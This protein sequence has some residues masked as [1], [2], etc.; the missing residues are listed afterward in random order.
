MSNLEMFRMDSD[1]E[2]IARAD[3]G[4]LE[5]RGVNVDDYIHTNAAVT[6]VI[7]NVWYLI[8]K[9]LCGGKAAARVSQTINSFGLVKSIEIL[10]SFADDL[11]GDSPV[12]DWIADAVDYCGAAKVIQALSFPKRFAPKGIKYKVDATEAF[13]QMQRLLSA[14]AY[15][16][17][18]RTGNPIVDKTLHAKTAFYGELT[19]AVRDTIKMLIGEGPD[20]SMIPDGPYLSPGASLYAGW[21]TSRSPAMKLERY[22][23]HSQTDRGPNYDE[24]QEPRFVT[25]YAEFTVEVEYAAKPELFTEPV[26][27]VWYIGVRRGFSMCFSEE[28]HTFPT[29]KHFYVRPSLVFKPGE[30][31]N[32]FL[33]LTVGNCKYGAELV[34]LES[35]KYV[36]GAAW[37]ATHDGK[38]R[39][40]KRLNGLRAWAVKLMQVP[41]NFKT[42]RT[43]TVERAV[44]MSDQLR[45]KRALEWAV[46]RTWVGRLWL[47]LS[48][49]TQNQL[50]AW[51][52]SLEGEIATIDISSASDWISVDLARDCFPGGWYRAFCSTRPTHYVVTS[53]RNK[54]PI[55]QPLS[56][57]G[58][59]GV[60]WTFLME[61]VFYLAVSLVAF[62]YAEALGVYTAKN[63]IQHIPDNFK[64]LRWAAGV[65]QTLPNGITIRT[66]FGR[67]YICTTYGDDCAMPEPVAAVFVGICEVFGITVNYSKSY[68]TGSF[69]ES[70]GGDYYR[71]WRGLVHDATPVYWSRHG[72]S[73]LVYNCETHTAEWIDDKSVPDWR[74]GEQVETSELSQLVMLQHK[75]WDY[76]PSACDYLTSVIKELV[77]NMTTHV[78]GTECSDLWGVEDVGVPGIL[79]LETGKIRP[80]RAGDNYLYVTDHETGERVAVNER[81]LFLQPTTN[82]NARY[83]YPDGQPES[84]VGLDDRLDSS[85][86]EHLYAQFLEHGAR[87]ETNDLL[88]NSEL[89]VPILRSISRKGYTDES[90]VV[91][92]LKP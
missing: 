26:E 8:T 88:E 63:Q 72:L 43:I 5:V 44:R 75:L 12:A 3:Y 28:P 84:L 25:S 89:D 9:D 24:V 79:D 90:T 64:R 1:A 57:L 11:R 78:A 70:C 22:S 47:S 7:C 66:D 65:C 67:P 40:V 13:K 62:Q 10:S 59:M 91:W 36:V 33:E 19:H 50:F 51:L 85:V 18:G 83:A 61:S 77:P 82:F 39:R 14:R 55:P 21:K 60:G 38:P 2:R 29:G 52:G 54:N 48:D 20:Y 32:T 23:N 81:T 17:A 4:S 41:K 87:Y 34:N 15:G 31:V 86:E 37:F 73:C 76:S 30:S 71:D 27:G 69:R 68:L 49:Q 74:N 80:L 45:L 42:P 58:P 92:V 53:A 16:S 6:I 46:K 56:T 35:E